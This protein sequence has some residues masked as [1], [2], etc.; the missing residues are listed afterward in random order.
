MLRPGA[1]PSLGPGLAGPGLAGG[2]GLGWRGRGGCGLCGGR[3][4]CGRCWGRVGPGD[5]ADRQAQLDLGAV[6]AVPDAGRATVALHPSDDRLAY[7]GAVVGH[8]VEVEPGAV[9]AHEGLDGIR[10]DLDVG[11]DRRARMAHGVPR[12]LADGLDE[13]V[14]VLVHG[15]V[16]GDD[17]LH[18]DA[19]EVLDL[20]HRGGQGGPERAG[21]R[22]LVVEVAAQLTLLGSGEPGDGH[23][24]RRLSLDEGK[25]LEH[26]VVQVGGDVGALGGPDAGGL[27]E[28]QVAPE[29]QDPRRGQHGDADEGREHGAGDLPQ[30]GEV[31][32]A[33][34]QADE[35]ED[36]EAETDHEPDPANRAAGADDIGVVELRPEEDRPDDDGDD[37]QDELGV[38]V[39]AGA[40]E[41]ERARDGKGGDAE[42]RDDDG[43]V[44]A[45]QP[46]AQAREVDQ[47]MGTRRR[48][49]RAWGAGR[50]HGRG[51]RGRGDGGVEVAV[52]AHRGPEEDVDGEPGTEGDGRQDQGDAD[53]DD[54][55]PE[56]VGHPHRDPGDDLAPAV[57]H[58]RG[59]RR[60][61]PC[62]S[63]GG[64]SVL[65]CR[66]H[67]SI[68]T[69]PGGSGRPSGPPLGVAS[70]SAQGRPSWLAIAGSVTL[71]A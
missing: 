34:E 17:E 32:A 63:H 31:G 29:A 20:T 51:A 4:L 8:L 40:A 45:A 19:V 69:H 3:R 11:A 25:G 24:V 30:L 37:G 9:V 47:V 44:A 48:R 55:Q 1:V 56:V 71:V 53:R 54:R 35:A 62:G 27:L 10:P 13:S 64:R 42:Q 18:R 38:D 26:R 60:G 33:H 2:G 6:G 7:P 57:A 39:E 46:G 14:E 16:A 58:E 49:A 36:G 43:L 41:P 15:A 5:L 61:P 67:R 12:G 59:T 28:A 65:G 66:L 22:V 21:S 70:G 50:R 23:G 68:L 52:P